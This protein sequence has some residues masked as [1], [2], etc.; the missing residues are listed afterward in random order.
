MWRFWNRR[1]L[2]IGLDIG[3]SSLKMAQ[4]SHEG[5]QMVAA[6]CW[7][8]PESSAGAGNESVRQ[9][10]I[11]EGIR[12]LLIRHPFRGRDVVVGLSDRTLHIQQLRVPLSAGAAS[13]LTKVL[14]R[15]AADRLP[16]AWGEAEVRHVTIGEMRHGESMWQEVV[17]LAAHRQTLGQI[18]DQVDEAGLR[19]VAMEPEACAIVRAYAHQF[20]RAEDDACRSLIVHIGH[21]RT[22]VLVADRT[23][24]W[25]LKYLNIGGRDMDRALANQLG[26]DV[27][28]ARRLRSYQGARRSAERDPE[29]E[30]TVSQAIR[31]LLQNLV[32]ELR[33]CLRYYSAVAR[34]RHPERV[35][36]GGGEA[37]SGLIAT[38][39][40]QLELP[41]FTFQPLQKLV[42][43]PKQ[44]PEAAWEVAV[45][46]S[47]RGHPGGPAARA[48]SPHESA[49][50]Q[51]AVL[52]TSG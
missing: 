24:F 48:A 9:E 30:R 8:L 22:L 47:L 5:T 25:F 42:R 49:T 43:R 27:R 44:L 51:P 40:A 4:L 39:S 52:E 33:M 19:V 50:G 11:T 12:E 41:M 36:V 1:A 17:L 13:D 2:P 15:E 31:P 18:V 46:L 37:H 26:I 32:R 38:L 14:P 28:Q 45:G 20:R 3:T 23:R 6:A 35:V 29:V 16:F 7:D 34:G 21:T 10:A